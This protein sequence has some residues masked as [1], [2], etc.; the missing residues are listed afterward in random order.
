MVSGKNPFVIR[1]SVFTIFMAILLSWPVRID[2]ADAK[3]PGMDPAKVQPT[4][5]SLDQSRVHDIYNEG[6]FEKVVAVIDSFTR[7]NKTFS[8]EDSIFIAKH[9]AVVYTANPATREKGK[10]YMF[11]LLDLVPS[12]KIVDMFVSD[13]IDRIFDKVKEEFVVRQKVLGR[14]Q[15]SPIEVNRFA[16][17]KMDVKTP[18]TGSSTPKSSAQKSSSRPMYWVAGGVAV[19]AIS[20][21]A[22][23]FLLQPEEPDD[24]VYPIH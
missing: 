2:G 19:V 5:N 22:A 6:D 16:L 10:S 20:G 13:E 14:K 3:K 4:I 17:D 11:R 15:S 21:A 9:L 12:A 18:T 1:F 8:L 24:K 7:V 23:Y